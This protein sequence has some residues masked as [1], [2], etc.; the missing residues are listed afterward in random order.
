MEAQKHHDIVEVLDK[1]GRYQWAQ[2]FW[3]CLP[4][5][6]VTMVNINF[7]FVA[8]D[9]DYRCKIPEC[10]TVDSTSQQPSW[11]PSATLDQCSKPLLSDDFYLQKGPCSKASFTK[12]TGRCTE[13][14]YESNN[15]IVSEL[16]LAC[17]PWKINLVGTIHNIGMLF[18]MLICGWMSDR[19]GRKPTMIFC[20]T[21]CVIGHLKQF[22][23]SYYMY[24]TVE[25]FE[26]MVS[27]GVYLSTSVMLI[28]LGSKQNRVFAGVLLACVIYCGESLFAGIAM[29]VPY[30]K[31]LIRII[32][33]PSVFFITYLFFFKESPRWLVVNGKAEEA[34]KMIENIAD[35]NKIPI[36]KQDLKEI[37]EEKLKLI[38]NIT[39]YEVKEGYK[40]IFRSTEIMKRLAVSCFC[41]FTCGFVY[42]GLMFNSV[43]LPGNKHIN[44]LLSTVMSF[45]GELMA[46]YLMNK[47]GRKLPLIVGYLLCGA[48]CVSSAYVTAIWGKIAMFLLGKMVISACF[49]GIITYTMELFPTSTRAS[50]LGFGSILSRTGAML[51]PL[52]PMLMPI[53]QVLPSVFFGGSALIS[54]LLLILTPETKDLPLL[55][56]IEQVD[57]LAR[58]TREM[59]KQSNKQI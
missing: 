29:L 44:F 34:K 22:A 15:T 53:A 55:D 51:A 2:Y 37:D 11:W 24:V 4:S 5:L 16:N 23:T 38:F 56:T 46:L 10:E 12:E 21:A 32:N 39:N 17:Q 49:T 3:A 58:Q 20:A 41:R 7:V 18:S 27:G 40:D 45:P 13:W 47:V 57:T 35:V 19:F 33:T 54:G 43:L 52:T 50:L 59:K 36:N 25:F 28:E 48:M 26:A 42:Y 9:M 1:F 31:N 6:V 8:G 30:W 14:I